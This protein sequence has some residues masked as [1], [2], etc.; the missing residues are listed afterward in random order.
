MHDVVQLDDVDIASKEL[1]DGRDIIWER[2]FGTVNGRAGVYMLHSFV[3][4]MF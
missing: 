2:R 1:E 3:D 4:A